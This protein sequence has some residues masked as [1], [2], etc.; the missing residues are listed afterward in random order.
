MAETILATIDKAKFKLD[1]EFNRYDI[2][3]SANKGIVDDEDNEDNE[4]DH[5]GEDKNKPITKFKECKFSTQKALRKYFAASNAKAEMANSAYKI[6][7]S[8][9]KSGRDAD[10]NNI[11]LIPILSIAYSYA[12]VE[13][14]FVSSHLSAFIS[15]CVSG[16]LASKYAEQIAKLQIQFNKLKHT[17]LAELQQE[18]KEN[19]KD[20]GYCKRVT[21]RLINIHIG[22]LKYIISYLTLLI[23]NNIQPITN[24][25]KQDL[26]AYKKLLPLSESLLKKCL[27]QY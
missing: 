8:I 7:Q 11:V 18:L 24:L 26:E 21:S 25:H 3:L 22:D 1:S 15:N 9:V 2:K 5:E 27:S 17:R 12:N 10:I 19:W 6:I 4:P 13:L 14:A 23:K 20:Y 16:Q